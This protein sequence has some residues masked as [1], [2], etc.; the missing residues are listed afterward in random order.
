MVS[1][2]SKIKFLLP[3]RAFPSASI[4][5]HS[6]DMIINFLIE[7]DLCEKLRFIGKNLKVYE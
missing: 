6:L 4:K 3:I 2:D 5:I 1:F 7:F